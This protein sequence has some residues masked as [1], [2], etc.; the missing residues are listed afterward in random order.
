MWD[1]RE[2]A[3]RSL[4]GRTLLESTPEVEIILLNLLQRVYADC[5]L[6]LNVAY[7]YY[8]IFTFTA[9]I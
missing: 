3:A 1:K 7:C 9:F 5:P 4:P 8:K 2:P 6:Q